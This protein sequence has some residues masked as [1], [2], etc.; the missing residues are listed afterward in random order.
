MTTPSSLIAPAPARGTFR[1]V[2]S[3]TLGARPRGLALAREKNLLLTWDED[4]WVYLFNRKGDRQGQV[5]TA[6]PLVAACCAEDGSAYAAVGGKGQVWWFR[7]DLTVAWERPL[8]H[9]AVAVALDMFGQYLAVADARGGLRVLDRHGR[10]VFQAQTPRPLHHLTFVLAA[11]FLL[12]SA[13]YGLV[14]CF[15]L[16]GQ[17]TWRDGLVA[18]VGSLAVTGDGGQIVLACFTE[19]LQ[20]Y[21]VTGRNLGR[22]QLAE[23]CRLAAL[24]VDGKRLLAADLAN[25]LRLLDRD[26]H[27]LAGCLLDRPPVALALSAL[28]DRAAAALVDRQVVALDVSEA[29]APA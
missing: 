11:P 29:A 28:A 17:C 8:S 4:N 22:L 16:A 21:H 26:G 12:G 25:G 5:R 14:A 15:D 13:D 6:A 27:V 10:E 2:W 19:W 20:C 1:P 18:N 3:Q 23:R 7:P 9:R 24:S